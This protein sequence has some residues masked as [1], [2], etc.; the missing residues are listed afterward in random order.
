MVD[1]NRLT[2]H[3]KRHVDLHGTPASQISQ[4]LRNARLSARLTPGTISVG[5]LLPPEPSPAVP[6]VP[7]PHT[8]HRN[9]V[10]IFSPLR[11]GSNADATPPHHL[12]VLSASASRAIPSPGRSVLPPQ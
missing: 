6:P 8:P 4:A 11:N 5:D 9:P 12:F 3:R 10:S 2:P 7:L 1:R